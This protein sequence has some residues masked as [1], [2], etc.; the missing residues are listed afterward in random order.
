MKA[1]G[2]FMLLPLKPGERAPPYPPDRRLGRLQSR[3][4]RYGEVKILTLPGLVL[5]PLGRQARRHSLYR[6][7]YPGS[8][9]D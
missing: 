7:S 4:G 2:K 9:I 6:L 5:E 8:L 1:Y 3:S